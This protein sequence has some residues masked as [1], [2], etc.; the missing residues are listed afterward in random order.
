MLSK[1]TKKEIERASQVQMEFSFVVSVLLFYGSKAIA[2]DSKLTLEVPSLFSA[3][4]AFN[5]AIATS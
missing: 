4:F 1:T 2:V 5:L 3:L